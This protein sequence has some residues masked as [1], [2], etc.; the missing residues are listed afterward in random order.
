MLKNSI[1]FQDILD[2]FQAD[3]SRQNDEFISNS[4]YCLCD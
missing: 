1:D 2:L 4:I 3:F